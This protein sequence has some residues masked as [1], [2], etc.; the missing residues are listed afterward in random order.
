MAVEPGL[1]PAQRK[2]ANAVLNECQRCAI[3]ADGLRA[4]NRDPSAYEPR[5]DHAK[6]GAQGLLEW[7]ALRQGG[8]R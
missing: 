1:Q 6:K 2:A 3:L 4:G 5:I 8:Q 7:D